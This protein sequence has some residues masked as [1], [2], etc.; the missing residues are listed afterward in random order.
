[1]KRLTPV[2][3][4]VAIT[5]S[6]STSASA[7]EA[8]E[9]Q[10]EALQA[11]IDALRAQVEETSAVAET[12]MESAE[13]NMVNNISAGGPS[14]VSIGGYGEL[15]YNNLDSGEE[16]DFHRFVLFFGNEFTESLRFFS[17]VELEHSLAGE[18][19]PGEV[20]LEQAYVE[21]DFNPN[22]SA[23]G[24]LFLVP[25]GILNETHEPPTFMGVER[26][27]I[28]SEII[29]STWWEAGAAVSGR[30]ESG[31]SYDLALHSGLAVP[32]TGGNAYRIRIGRQ[33]VAEADA[34][35]LAYT[36]RLR[37]TGMP[38]L[39]AAVTLQY[40]ENITQSADPDASATLIEA[41]I[42][43]NS[44]PFGFRAMVADWSI[45]GATA[46]ALGKDS[47]NGF[48]L[49]PSYSITPDWRI[50]ARYGEYN[51]FDGMPG[52][53]AVEQTDFGVNWY[54]HEDVVIKADIMNISGA[55]DDDGFNLGVGYQF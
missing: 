26:N 54:L 16:I 3:I 2:A 18:G 21:Y 52:S 37:Y 11:Q 15:H 47:Q 27:R 40:Q 39:E 42:N 44:G 34:N 45:D 14:G 20:E 5:M 13:A 12:A 7:Q 22:L 35:D 49:E 25:V 55:A 23:K 50:F 29:P 9:A 24:G 30:H 53:Q 8:L 51:T 10:I 32:T 46:E 36:G 31:F 33:K 17:E 43:Y 4:A 1:M 41:H 19:A 6:L 38:G 28:E 48:Y